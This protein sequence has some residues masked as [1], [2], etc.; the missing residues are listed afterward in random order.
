MAL[1]KFWK[2]STADLIW[3]ENIH[4]LCAAK[5]RTPTFH[6]KNKK[7]IKRKKLFSVWKPSVIKT[8]AIYFDWS[9]GFSSK[10]K[11]N[12]GQAKKTWRSKWLEK[13]PKK[14][15][16]DFLMKWDL[17]FFF[18]I[19]LCRSWKQRKVLSKPK[20]LDKIP[21]DLFLKY[22]NLVHFPCI[23]LVL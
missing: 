1:N 16:K 18:K 11:A 22:C 4:S 12:K 21:G 5:I 13:K 9:R 15:V 17:W 3:N 19:N 20:V 10:K 6:L 7:K 2:F 14:I 8:S 23:W